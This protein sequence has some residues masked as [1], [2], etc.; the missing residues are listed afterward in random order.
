MFEAFLSHEPSSEDG[1]LGKGPLRELTLV[2]GWD[3]GFPETH[4]S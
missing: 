1:K 2:S 3:P 4:L